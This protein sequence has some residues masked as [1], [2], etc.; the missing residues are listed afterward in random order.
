MLPPTP[1][2]PHLSQCL[3]ALGASQ[4]LPVFIQSSAL[5]CPK[6]RTDKESEVGGVFKYILHHLGNR[7]TFYSGKR[8]EPEGSEYLPFQVGEQQVALVRR[9]DY[10]GGP[11]MLTLW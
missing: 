11:F 7:L 2:F 8:V 5:V 10:A 6:V 3:P 9:G 1:L 4:N